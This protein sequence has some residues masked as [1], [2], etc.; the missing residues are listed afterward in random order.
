MYYKKGY[1]RVRDTLVLAIF[2]AIGVII[3]VK[4]NLQNIFRDEHLK[5]IYAII[6]ILVGVIIFFL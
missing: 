5:K 1:L 3:G 6:S 2:I 4:T